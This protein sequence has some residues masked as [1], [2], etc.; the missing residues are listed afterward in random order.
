M[1]WLAIGLAVVSLL[2]AVFL[3]TLATPKCDRHSPTG[4]RIGEAI[5]IEGCP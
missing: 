2:A 1:K 5:L 3:L 4:P